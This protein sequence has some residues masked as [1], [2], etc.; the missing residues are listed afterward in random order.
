[1]AFKITTINLPD[2]QLI[3]AELGNR[4]L[5]H[6]LKDYDLEQEFDIDEIRK[7]TT[8]QNAINNNWIIVKDAEDKL[9]TNLKQLQSTANSIDADKIDYE[10]SNSIDWINPIPNLVSDALDQISARLKNLENF[11]NNT[12]T[13]INGFTGSVTLTTSNISEG[14]NLYWTQSRFDNAF[15]L[16]SINAL[17]DV[18]TTTNP[19]NVNQYLSWN[20]SNWVPSSLP[21]FYDYA[22]SDNISSTTLATFTIKTILNTNIPVNGNYIVE[23][24]AEVQAPA[25]NR[26]I[27]VEF[28]QGATVL[29]SV[30][31][32]VGNNTN[33]WNSISGFKR[34]SLTPGTH[35]FT[36]QFASSVSGAQV[37]IRNARIKITRIS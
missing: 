19:P 16:K 1:M 13:S 12:V 29:N 37:N 17:T 14:I 20:G 15:S 3:V 7:S 34:V 18:D 30:W 33:W 25:T 24:C 26:Q 6:P 28:R 32:N 11:T 35:T 2:N 5:S 21:L 4:I 23:Y 10:P 27:L 9:I 22:E 31:V 36:I 8:I